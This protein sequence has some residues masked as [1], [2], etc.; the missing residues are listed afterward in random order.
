[1]LTKSMDNLDWVLVLVLVL[2]LVVQNKDVKNINF[3]TLEM[4]LH[5]I[6][7]ISEVWLYLMC[8]AADG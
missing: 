3:I 8:S 2:A 5:F 6:A 7:Y 1:M 4:I